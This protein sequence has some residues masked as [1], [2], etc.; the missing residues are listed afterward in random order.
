VRVPAATIRNIE[1]TIGRIQQSLTDELRNRPWRGDPNPL[2]GHC[3]VASEA[4]YYLLGGKQAG[5]VPQSVRHEGSPHWYLYNREL[6]LVV[7]PTASQFRTPVPIDQARGRGFLTAQP[8]RRAAEVIRRVQ[9][10][11]HS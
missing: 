5:W 6:D 11:G 9:A 1:S 4:L 8:S 7:D 3:Y 10:L 2:A